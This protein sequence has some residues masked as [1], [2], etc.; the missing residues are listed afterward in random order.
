[1]DYGYGLWALVIINSAIFIVFALSFFR[2]GNRRD[3]KAMGGFT[4]F[5]VA[6]FTEMY[7]FPLTIYL[8]TGAFGSR[9]ESLTLTHN[10]G[11][12]WSELIGWQ[13]DPHMSPFHIASYL[14]I[15]GGMWVIVAAWRVLWASARTDTLATTGP[16]AQVRHPQYAGF[17]AVMVGFLLQWPTLPTLVMFP[18]LVGVYR[19]LAIAEE[20]SVGEEFTGTWAAY[21]ARTPRFIPRR[22]PAR[23]SAPTP[24]HA[25]PGGTRTARRDAHQGLPVPVTVERSVS[26]NEAAEGAQPQWPS[27]GF[28]TEWCIGSE[29][30]PPAS[31]LP[32]GP[33]SA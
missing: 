33:P 2:P 31:R 28:P 24:P 21:A 8:L 13:G 12:L 15:G 6:L 19:R 5:V 9:F 17:L 20:R 25:Q 26:R 23:A 18:I 1:M 29:T 10:G 30:R 7:G 22:R 27:H 11:H 3:W 16:Y 32:S 4:A 14:F